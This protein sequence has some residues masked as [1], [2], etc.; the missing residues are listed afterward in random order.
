MGKTEWARCLDKHIYWNGFFNL[1]K[2]VDDAKYAIFD[3]IQWD[4]FKYSYKQWLGAQREFE[5]TDKYRHKKTVYWGKPCI[6]LLNPAEY[7][8]Y[9][10][11]WDANW[12]E[13]NCI[14]VELFDKLYE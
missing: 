13:G 4:S 14:K 8:V 1:D 12:I 6:L 9:R 10:A 7:E 5:C 11:N 3:D 2:F